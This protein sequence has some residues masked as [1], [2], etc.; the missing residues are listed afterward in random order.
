MNLPCLIKGF[1]DGIKGFIQWS[2]CPLFL[3]ERGFGIL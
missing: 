2:I 1:I 3:F